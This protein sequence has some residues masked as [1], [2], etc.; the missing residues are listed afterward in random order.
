MAQINQRQMLPVGTVLDGRY[1]IVQ[2]LASGGFGNTYVAEHLSLGGQV[3]VKEFF[4]RGTNHRSADGTTVEVSNEENT[5]LFD[6]QLNKFRR[7][8][9]RIF[10]LHN[11]HIIHVSDLFDANGTSYYVMDL[12]PGMSLAEQTRQQ[13]LSEQE[14]RDAALQ[15]LDALE[16]MH[17]AG[18]YHLDVKPGNIMRDSRGHCT[19]IDFGASK[20]LTAGER[21][22][23]SSSSMSYTPGYAPVEQVTQQS[24]NIGPW[25]DFYALGATLYRLVTGA[26]PPEVS[27][28]DFAPNGRQ[29]P[30]PPSV[31]PALRHAI[32]TLMNPIHTLRPQTDAE[33][34]ALLEGKDESTFY[35]DPSPE[36]YIGE[37]INPTSSGG[38]PLTPPSSPNSS[39]NIPQGPKPENQ[40]SGKGLWYALVGVAFL[41]L[42]LGILLL[43]KGC[44]DKSSV[45]EPDDPIDVPDTLNQ[46]KEEPKPKKVVPPA[47]RSIEVFT[48]GGVIFKM[49]RVEG[50][51]FT[52]GATS[53]QEGPS[54]DETPTHQVTLSD[55]YIGETEVTQELWEAIM[56][57]NQSRCKGAKHPVERVSWNDC[58]TFISKLNTKTGKTFR[59]PTEAEWE[60]AARG[61]KNSHRYQYAGSNNIN[62][63]A[64]YGD[65]SNSETHPVGQKSPNEL[66]L[67]DMAGN[68]WEWCQDWYDENYYSKSPRSNPCNKTSASRRVNRGGS[69][70]S[71]GAGYCRVSTRSNFSPGDRG[72]GVGLRLAL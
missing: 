17:S 16:A 38:S 27:V 64:W 59:L 18:L 33:V 54:D 53:E 32:S 35:N 30:Y 11:D 26:P 31:S 25:T 9:R 39:Q 23:F 42:I 57:D 61:G 22:T 43:T 24:K 67:Y 19:L 58:Q 72:S 63:V 1:R 50:G 28:D 47:P 68:V 52:M 5:G 2:Y 45:E 20:Q 37:Q 46:Q 56:G 70:L 21:A 44:D 4:M 13:P 6:A 60:Y 10:E 66:G 12:I 71:G 29:F 15:V 65:N 55:Y 51:T 69:C 48:V 41:A 7:E 36:M 34:K 14:A 49:I 40:S 62:S 8:A 3:A